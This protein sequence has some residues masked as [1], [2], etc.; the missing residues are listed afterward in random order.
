M[1]GN[2]NCHQ[3]TLSRIVSF[4]LVALLWLLF[5]SAV[6]AGGLDWGGGGGD[7]TG[8]TAGCT[9]DAP[10]VIIPGPLGSPVRIVPFDEQTYLIAD[11]S[12]KT[13]SWVDPSG[14]LSPFIETLG[15]PLSVAINASFRKNGTLK[16]AYYFV[17]ND[18]ARTIDVYYEKND[19]FDLVGQYPVGD[20][21][22]QALDM[23][24][25][26]TQNHLFVVDGL[27][28]E[29]K[30]LQPDGQLVRSFGFGVL[31]D[32]KG[33]DIDAVT[34]EIYV[35]D[36]GD[37]VVYPVIPASIKVFDMTG[38]HLSGRT[39]SGYGLFS[40]PQGLSLSGDKVYLADN[41]LAQIL[42]FDRATGAKTSSF[43]C[44]GSS[45]G[46]LLLPMDVALGDGQN[47]YVA[48]NRNM[49]VTVLPLTQP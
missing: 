18:D 32:P 11:Y 42:E 7:D 27:A 40:R 43:G 20:N 36:Y 45:D 16:E 49:R 12:R 44:K 10:L 31:S 21:G 46:H 8:E 3:G 14:I 2:R 23:V 41:L 15:K 13:L 47:L 1:L 4:L 28:R 22:I 5:C 29:V 38:S 30:V 24:F 48:D 37:P 17:G 19:Q 6:S 9:P 25:D 35:S 34:G 33:V 26:Q 39:I